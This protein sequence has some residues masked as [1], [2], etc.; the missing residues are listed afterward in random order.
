MWVLN[1]QAQDLLRS[2]SNW[3]LTSR[4]TEKQH[5]GSLLRLLGETRRTAKQSAQLRKSQK[6]ITLQFPSHGRAT[7]FGKPVPLPLVAE[8]ACRGQ[9]S[10]LS[11]TAGLHWSFYFA[12]RILHT[13]TMLGKLASRRAGGYPTKDRST[14]DLVNSINLNPVAIGFLH[15]HTEGPVFNQARHAA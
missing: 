3:T 12:L 10:G 8:W 2:L 1:M 6:P 5:A 9:G 14:L 15:S 13:S 4:G 11:Q 7:A